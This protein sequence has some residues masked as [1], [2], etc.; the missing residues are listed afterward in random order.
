MEQRTNIASCFVTLTYSE[1]NLPYWKNK[2]GYWHLNKK[3][4]QNF[5]KRVRKDWK[6]RYF[7][8]GEYGEITGRPHYH[9]A[10]FGLGMVHSKY[11]QE[12]WGLGYTYTG[13]LTKDSASYMTE[14]IMKG[15]NA[16]EKRTN[17]IALQGRNPEFATMSRRPGIGNN[18]IERLCS[19]LVK[20]GYYDKETILREIRLGKKSYALGRYLTEKYI[21]GIGID[22]EKNLEYYEYQNE[23]FDKHIGQE[24]VYFDS[25]VKEKE[26]ERH[27]QEARRKIYRSKRRL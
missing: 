10:I 17:V 15:W 18:Y 16:N 7:A 21:I 25:I 3:D 24:E 1:D 2:K 9:A 6:I 27:N 11:I 13:D 20:K 5:F 4:L 26:T 12:K 8:V 19:N 14:Y 22:K 23:M